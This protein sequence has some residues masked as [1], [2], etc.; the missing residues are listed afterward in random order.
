MENKMSCTLF[1]VSDEVSRWCSFALPYRACKLAKVGLAS[2]WSL[3]ARWT[4]ACGGHLLWAS[5]AGQ[6]PK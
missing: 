2:F 4:G 1:L 5:F 6:T 3:S